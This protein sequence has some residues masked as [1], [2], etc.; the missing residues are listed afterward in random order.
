M[1]ENGGEGARQ[2]GTA[3]LAAGSD[4]SSGS[5]WPGQGGLAA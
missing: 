2:D 4:E 5:D 3:A 1:K